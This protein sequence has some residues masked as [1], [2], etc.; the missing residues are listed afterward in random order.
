MLIRIDYKWGD[1]VVSRFVV[2]TN[3]E[4]SVDSLWVLTA[5]SLVL[6]AIIRNFRLSRMIIAPTRLLVSLEILFWVGA[7]V[8]TLM[9]LA[10]FAG[11][12]PQLSR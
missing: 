8:S 5:I 3:K 10:Q 12:Y 2:N 6:V 1:A 11:L 4:E 9:Y 7:I